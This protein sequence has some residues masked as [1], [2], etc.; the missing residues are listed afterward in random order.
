MAISLMLVDPAIS[1]HG[2]ALENYE[3]ERYNHSITVQYTGREGDSVEE[4]VRETA[5]VASRVGNLVL[6]RGLSQ[7]G[8]HLIIKMALVKKDGW[9][10]TTFSVRYDWADLL[11]LAKSHAPISD[12]ATKGKIESIWLE[13]WPAM[14]LNQPAPELFLGGHGD[15]ETPEDIENP[16]GNDLSCRRRL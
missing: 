13:Y 11:N 9:F 3:D 4:Q 14:C 2:V 15:P 5:E 1:G 6:D 12:L 16:K 8:K 7:P 10:I